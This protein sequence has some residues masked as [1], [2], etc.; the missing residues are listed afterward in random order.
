M[1]R[2]WAAALPVVLAA[3][4]AVAVAFATS[5][6]PKSW[7]WAHDLLLWWSIVAGLVVL[8]ALVAVA[9]RRRE[10]GAIPDLNPTTD[11]TLTDKASSG[12]SGIAVVVNVGKIAERTSSQPP[13]DLTQ[14]LA[15]S[16]NANIMRPQNNLPARNPNFTGRSAILE[17]ISSELAGRPG[18]PIA[19]QGMGG[20][21]KS[22]IALE[23]AHRRLD[24]RTNYELVGWVR[25][26]SSIT[27][28]EDI[29]KI[30]PLMGVRATGP[31]NTV[32]NAALVALGSREQWLLVFDNA[33]EPDEMRSWL[34]GGAGEVLITTRNRG[35][36]QLASQ[37]SVPD[38]ERSESIAFLEKRTG[39]TE[40]PAADELSADLG[41][42]P[43]A[44]AQAASY[45]D[46]N[47]MSISDYRDL[48][49]NP[50]VSSGLRAAGLDAAEYPSSVAGT[51]RLN[52]E[53]LEREKPGGADLLRLLAFLDPDD[54]DLAVIAGGIVNLGGAIAAD[55]SQ[56]KDRVQTVGALARTGLITAVAGSRVKVHRLVQAATRD[57]LDASGIEEW[58]GRALEVLVAT[59]PRRPFE[60]TSWP[61]CASLAAHAQVVADRASE[62]PRLAST[63][64]LLL[65]EL[66]V[67]LRSAAQYPAALQTLEHALS[68]E[69]SAPGDNN[70]E[71]ANIL[72]TLGEVRAE[73]GTLD[74][75]QSTLDR[76]LRIIEGT[77]GD[78]H[79]AVVGPL[80]SLGYVQAQNRDLSAAYSSL[81]RALRTIEN[82]HGAEHPLAARTL[83]NL[84]N[85]LVDLGDL[86]GAM[87]AFKR[88]LAIF[89]MNLPPGS[90]DVARALANLAEVQSETSSL[91]EAAANLRRALAIFES[92]YPSDYPEVVKTRQKLS[93]VENELNS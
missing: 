88:V 45:I 27:I 40:V 30:A 11:K 34:P 35:W 4:L 65:G 83:G 54:I 77:Y 93:Q 70:V 86:E 1:G 55:F 26:E 8:S 15:T 47:G 82:V 67:Y 81:S 49:R 53:R 46:I 57:Q 10:S 7:S 89:E 23:Y 66:G 90:P 20:V 48:Y 6:V 80:N 36:T 73:L 58:A 31:S 63:A 69:E 50:S 76:A 92:A 74:V 28:A 72:S 64:G 12:K 60:H 75:A 41:D 2:H 13:S 3:I 61:L 19:L 33:Y 42:L 39:R 17:R 91:H 59:F 43:L 9:Q 56:P 25:A 68:I 21:G 18:T 24:Q 32:A 71:V 79:P 51:W 85:V 87:A 5:V 22:Q 38:F 16:E 52:F 14:I 44:L 37:I 78:D 29:A 84:G 62:Y